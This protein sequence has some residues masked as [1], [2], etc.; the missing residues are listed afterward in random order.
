MKSINKIALILALLMTLVFPT[1][2][3]GEDLDGE[4]NNTTDETQVSSEVDQD[5]D[6]ETDEDIEDEEVVEEGNGKGKGNSK[7]WKEAKAAVEAEKDEIEALKDG[8]EDELEALE[9]SLEA[10][11]ALG[12]EA[13]IAEIKLQLEAKKLEMN[14]YK[15]QMKAKIQEMQEI[16]RNKYTQEEL[17]A[18][19]EVSLRFD[20]IENVDVIPVENVLFKKGNA[21]FDTPPVI[22]EGR[23]LIPVR[24]VSEALGAKVE[25]DDVE[26]IVTI[27]KD[28]KVIVFSL[29]EGTVTVN[30]ETVEIDVPAEIMNNRTMVPLRFIAEQLEL[31]VEWDQETQTINID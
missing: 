2:A 16:V 21:K 11:E 3:F 30:E 17:E 10:A 23:T 4:T 6:V 7:V 22:K 9:T 5:A 15:V 20:S 19:K 27:T 12:D 31:T 13:A 24:A 1:V 29:A 25:Y 14:E 28:G 8:I 18:L 26:K